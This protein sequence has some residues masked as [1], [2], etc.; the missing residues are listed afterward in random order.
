VETTLGDL[1]NKG[2]N[3]NP[4]NNP[5]QMFELWSVPSFPSGSPEV[6]KGAD[7]G[8]AKQLVAP[9]T[10]LLCKINPRINR[11]WRVGPKDKL[12]QIASTE[13]IALDPVGSAQFLA[14]ALQESSFRYR[15]CADV[16]G[17]GGSLTRAR[18]REA[19]LLTVPIAPLAEQ[20]RI[21]AKLDDLLGRSRRAKEALAEIPALLERYRQSVLAAAF[22]GDLTAD[23]R[24]KHPE[25]EPA[26]EL[27]KRIRVE[28]RRRWEEAELAR[29]TA[30]GKTPT[31]E[32]WKERYEEPSQ[33]DI[34]DGVSL[35]AGWLWTSMETVG[36]VHL[37]RQRAPQYQTGEHTH[38]YLRVANIKDDRIDSSDVNSM[39]FDPE[40]FEHY[41]LLP[42]DIL[43]SE[44]QS[45]ELVGQSA[46]YEGGIEG[47]CFQKTLH[48]FRRYG[49][50]PSARFAQLVFRH[51]VRSGFFR[52]VASLT[53][54]IAHLT[55]VRLKPLAFP[56][57]PFEEQ[58]V[59]EHRLTQAMRQI[60]ALEATADQEL[61]RLDGVERSILTRAFR[62]ELVP[63]DPADE[64]ASVLLDRIRAERAAAPSPRTRGRRTARE[65]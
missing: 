18:P 59:I 65:D 40:D 63:Q 25:A 20:R 53:V 16:S 5:Q 61:E 60:D 46:I 57:P 43:L 8:S 19:L 62:G 28:R 42:G 41:R 51:Y 56:L 4:S 48:R 11:V 17:V 9:D 12:P 32:K 6:T 35:P 3:V 58:K 50:A 21:V 30:K 31:D 45:P 34:I 29:L 47:L 44:G 38:P 52:S 36:D 26:S 7:I 49:S 33:P 15:L 55:L 24:A 1:A 13:W 39:D 37:G 27:L 14:Y 10:V 23:W 2:A 54:N 22:R 64:P